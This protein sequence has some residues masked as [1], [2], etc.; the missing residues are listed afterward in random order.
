LAGN[1]QDQVPPAVSR[2]LLPH[3]RQVIAVRR[4][5]AVLLGPFGLLAGT[6]AAGLVTATRRKDAAALRGTWGAAGIALLISAIRLQAWLSSYVV[7]TNSRLLYID[8]LVS[9]KVRAIPLSAV[10]AIELRRSLPGRLL[11]YGTFVIKTAGRDEKIR[12][13][14]YPEQ[15]YLE[16]CGT[17]TPADGD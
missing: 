15:L 8:G 2:Y 6:A 5:P 4:H 14:P 3:E 1:V 9:V 13:L 16:V 10:R 12:V 17:L 7:M 11:G